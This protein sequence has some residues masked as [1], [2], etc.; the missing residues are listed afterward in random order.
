MSDKRANAK[1]LWDWKGEEEYCKYKQEIRQGKRTIQKLANR[2]ASRKGISEKQ[3]TNLHTL[4]R[5]LIDDVQY[6]KTVKGIK[7]D[8]LSL[9]E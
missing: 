7:Q 5:K 9:I 3:L 6:L 8:T 1:A 4:T 2:M